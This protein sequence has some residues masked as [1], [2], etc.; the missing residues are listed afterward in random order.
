MYLCV[1]VCMYVRMFVIFVYIYVK[2]YTWKCVRIYVC[3]GMNV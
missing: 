2:I 3:I 1:I